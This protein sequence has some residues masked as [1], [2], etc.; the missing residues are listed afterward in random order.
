M[1]TTGLPADTLDG[2]TINC[3]S[4]S[5]DCGHYDPGVITVNPSKLTGGAPTLENCGGAS[6]GQVF[7]HEVGH[8]LHG[9][10]VMNNNLVNCVLPYSPAQTTFL[11]GLDLLSTIPP[12]V[13][14]PGF[15]CGN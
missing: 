2:H 6:I 10:D 3:S 14:P 12:V 8:A 9:T 11:V 15:T 1:I 13:Y 5:N 4:V 7:L